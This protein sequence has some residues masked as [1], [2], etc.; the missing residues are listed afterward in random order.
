MKE[1]LLD[2][3]NKIEHN[4]IEL[5]YLITKLKEEINKIER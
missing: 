5:T 4:A 3:L 2:K 1:Y